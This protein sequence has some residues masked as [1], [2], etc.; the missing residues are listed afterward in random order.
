MPG[1]GNGGKKL[2][3]P[4]STAKWDVSKADSY[5]PNKVGFPKVKQS[6]KTTI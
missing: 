4:E 6:V 5:N 3:I 1:N 2:S